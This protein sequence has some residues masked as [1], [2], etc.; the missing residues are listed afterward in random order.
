MRNKNDEPGI[1]IQVTLTK[2]ALT[3]LEDM[4][5]NLGF[6]NVQALMLAATIQYV[7]EKRETYLMM[8]EL[9]EGNF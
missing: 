7:S 2:K 5:F 4:A 9:D 8:K 3:G 6:R 1:T